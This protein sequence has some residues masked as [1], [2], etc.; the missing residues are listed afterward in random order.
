KKS[1][2]QYRTRNSM[3]KRPLTP[4]FAFWASW[5]FTLLVNLTVYL[6]EVSHVATYIAT[7][8]GHRSVQLDSIEVN[9]GFKVINILSVVAQYFFAISKAFEETMGFCWGCRINHGA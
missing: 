5:R 8:F 1:E 2:C 3:K 6:R 4:F 7:Y 9:D